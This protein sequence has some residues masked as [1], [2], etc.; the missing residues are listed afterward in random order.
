MHSSSF[1][2]LFLLRFIYTFIGVHHLKCDTH[3]Q[4]LEPQML[5][6]RF[7]IWPF[8]FLQKHKT[9]DFYLRFPDE[10]NLSHIM[11]RSQRLNANH[12]INLANR[13]KSKSP[14]RRESICLFKIILAKKNF[15]LNTIVVFCSFVALNGIL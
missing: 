12:T 4:T 11:K 15:R 9:P 7:L 8:P 5:M 6:G 13:I 10:L 14:S 2:C 1:S 3:T